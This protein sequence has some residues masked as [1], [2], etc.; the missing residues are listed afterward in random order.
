MAPVPGYKPQVI[1]MPSR[2]A[3]S[4]ILLTVTSQGWLIK[5]PPEK[6]S[7]LLKIEAMCMNISQVYSYHLMQ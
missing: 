6:H 1:M 5:C 2:S 7:A 4:A 3:I